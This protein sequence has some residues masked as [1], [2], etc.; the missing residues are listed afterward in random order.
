MALHGNRSV[1]HKSPCRFLN[2]GPG[3]MRSA[4]NKHGM[5]RNAFQA[6]S[7]LSATPLGHLSPSAWVLPK[8]AGGM[9]SRNVTRLAL[10]GAGAVVGGITSPGSAAIVFTVADAAGQLISS[11]S[12]TA[13]FAFS[14]N[15]PL[16]TASL[17]AIGAASFILSA[18][19]TPGA[20]A[21]AS[22]SASF[23]TAMAAA[24]LPTN[25]APPVR[26]ASASFSIT[27]AMVPYAIG[28]MTGSTVDASTLTVDAIT[29][30]VWSAVAAQYNDAGSMGAKLNSAASGGVDYAALGLAVWQSVSRTLTAGDALPTTADIS[31]EVLATL[32]DQT[33][34]VD[35]RKV[36]G[37]NIGGAG[38]E[39]D[40]WG[41]A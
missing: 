1:L 13:A 38:S 39:A 10:S 36:N 31:A 40:P 34:P 8:T 15:T 37:Q 25:D 12:G 24:I 26:T 35:M 23:M 6:Y 3:I 5:Q 2:G 18:T 41:P 11:G 33:I 19:G 16:L 4:F 30:A 21:S 27:G 17:G 32:Q 28:Q 29:T 20:E 9:S 22:G 7:P 14:T